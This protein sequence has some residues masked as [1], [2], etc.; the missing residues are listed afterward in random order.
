MRKVKFKELSYESFSKYGTFKNLINPEG[1]KLGE[2][3]AEFYR[4]LIQLDIGLFTTASFSIT[5]I[6][7]R[8]PIIDAM[9]YH[10]NSG[11]LNLP[12]DGDVLLQVAPATMENEC[13]TDKI[14]VFRVPKGTAVSLRRGVW[15]LG[16]YVYNCEL[17]NVVVG[18]QERAYAEDCFM[19]QIPEDKQVMIDYD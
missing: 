1:E 9:E 6:K 16:P 2:E 13:P 11:E 14:E 7:K 5:R 12:L 19:Y 3:P 18:V 17:A 15:H 8:P 10:H 4:D